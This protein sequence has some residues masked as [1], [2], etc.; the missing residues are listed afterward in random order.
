MPATFAHPA[1]A[2]PLRRFGLPTSALT[3]G[4]MAPDLAYVLPVWHP[5]M[6]HSLTGLFAFALPVGLLAW[7]LVQVFVAPG[8]LAAAPRPVQS[9]FQRFA[10]RGDWS[11][12][13]FC[14]AAVGVVLGAATH[15]GIDELTHGYGWGPNA[16]PGVFA[17]RPVGGLPVYKLLQYGLGLAGTLLLAAWT[18]SAYRAGPRSAWTA[19]DRVHVVR[20]L[21]AFA[22]LAGLGAAYA[23]A[24][25]SG[26]M[27]ALFVKRL[28]V[29]TVAATLV[30]LAAAMVGWGVWVS[31]SMRR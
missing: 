24:Q 8:L 17:A 5:W 14:L 19:E 28:V 11:G 1:F 6:A 23:A 3:V 7:V 20:L 27:D 29:R 18:F 22:G 12:R 31:V 10:P 9:S 2:V 13:A 15:I 25:A 4:A 21:A 16:M 30:L 26:P